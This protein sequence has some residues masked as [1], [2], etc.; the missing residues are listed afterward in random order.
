MDIFDR[1]KNLIGDES[2]I[3]RCEKVRAEHSKDCSSYHIGNL[4]DC[5]VFPKNV[6]EIKKIVEFANE[7]NIPLVP[8]GLGTSVEG[9]IVPTRGGISLSFQ[10]MNNI[11]E[12]CPEDFYVKVQPGVTRV[13]LNE[14]LKK[15]GMF[16]PVDPGLDATI[17]GMAATNA[18]GTNAVY[19]GAMKHQILGLEVVLAT[20]EVIRTGGAYLKSSSGYN[21]TSLFVGS[22][23]T[24]GIFTELI[25]KIHSVPRFIMTAKAVFN[26]VESA[27]HAAIHVLRNNGSV[28]KLELLDQSTISAINRYKQTS[29]TELPTLFIEIMENHFTQVKEMLLLSDCCEL[30]VEDIDEKREQLWSIRHEAAFAIKN[31]F[32]GKKLMATDVCV[33]LT[34]LPVAIRNARE[35]MDRNDMKGSI[36]GHVGDG[37]FHAVFA[38]AP[39]DQGDL[40]RAQH[41]NNAIVQFAL[42]NGGTCSGEHGIGLGKM[43]YLEQEHGASVFIMKKIKDMFDPKGILNPGKIFTS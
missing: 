42:N 20:G 2:R 23:G 35:V 38:V 29:Y 7:G 13:Q 19:Y 6:E 14:E 33:P 4:P 9:Q 36:L 12:V 31:L 8:F 32:P 30:E 39:F 15:Y 18:S 43:N 22:E 5:V 10:K 26:D 24:L 3:T 28:C 21:L 40:E 16:F 34:I 27:S 1:L 17:G 41:V 11:I 25:L 37:N